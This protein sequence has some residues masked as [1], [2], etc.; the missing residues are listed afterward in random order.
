MKKKNCFYVKIVFTL[1]FVLAL[2]SCSTFIDDLNRPEG[3]VKISGASYDGLTQ[4]SPNSLAFTLGHP[5]TIPNLYVCPHE[6]T[7]SEYETYCTYHG[8]SNSTGT[9]LPL[10]PNE[11]HGL[12]DNH[13]TYYVNWYDAIAYCNTRSIAEGRRPCYSVN[14]ETDYTKWARGFIPSGSGTRTYD[15][16]VTV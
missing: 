3:F 6:V 4:V 13:P 14:G 11:Q 5:V 10:H 7:Q 8:T 1:A 15:I 2:A 16:W 12:G 9:P